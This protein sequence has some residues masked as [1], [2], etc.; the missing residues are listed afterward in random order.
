MSNKKL[1]MILGTSLKTKKNK[2]NDD[3]EM[4][5][6]LRRYLDNAEANLPKTQINKDDLDDDEPKKDD[7][8]PSGSNPSQSSKPSCSKSG[9]KK[10]LENSQLSIRQSEDVKTRDFDKLKT[11]T[12]QAQYGVLDISISL[13]TYRDVKCSINS[14]WRSQGIVSK[15]RIADQF[16]IQ[17]K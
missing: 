13:C 16:N 5:K 15:Y 12:S 3:M 6:L 7:Q 10:K 17:D 4:I 8:N 2:N 14:N 1:I 11:S 9:E